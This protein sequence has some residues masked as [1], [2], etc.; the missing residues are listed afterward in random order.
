MS[1][2][3]HS[4]VKHYKRGATWPNGETRACTVCGVEQRP[5]RRQATVTANQRHKDN[6][7]T[8][9]VGYCPEHV[10]EDL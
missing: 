1:G 7:Y 4:Q 2:F 5:R 8:V 10:P 3:Y 9:P 6:H